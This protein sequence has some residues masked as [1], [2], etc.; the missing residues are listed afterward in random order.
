MEEAGGGQ[1]QV[2]G[3]RVTL[4]AFD[5]DRRDELAQALLSFLP[6]P[7]AVAADALP[8]VVLETPSREDAAAAF[9]ALE[10][11]GGTVAIERVWVDRDAT[12]ARAACPS[13]GSARTQPF[14]HAGPA[15]R[16]NTRCI[17]CGH[18]FKVTGAR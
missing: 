7:T 9:D 16:V 8:M 2:L 15:A 1:D 5:E 18:L 13:C 4:T 10:E 3:A 11:A 17:D 14:G 6:D 12:T